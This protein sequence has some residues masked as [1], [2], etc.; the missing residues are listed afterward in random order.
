MAIC[1][2]GEK[3]IWENDIDFMPEYDDGEFQIQR[4]NYE[5]NEI[6]KVFTGKTLDDVSER[7]FLCKNYLRDFERERYNLKVEHKQRIA[8][9]LGSTVQEISEHLSKEEEKKYFNPNGRFKGY[10]AIQNKHKEEQS[11]LTKREIIKACENQACPLNK[12]CFCINNVVKEGRGS[13]A[14]QNAIK[15]KPKKNLWSGLYQ[16]RG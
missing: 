7:I 10:R 3:E 8:K 9:M 1:P 14:S 13:C 11:K 15:P 4:C 12:D 6:N 2:F 16:N 5:K